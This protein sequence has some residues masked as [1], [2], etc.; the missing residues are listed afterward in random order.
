MIISD[1]PNATCN[2]SM[3]ADIMF[4]GNMLEMFQLTSEV[5]VRG[6]IIR[7]LNKPRDLDQL[8]TWLLKTCVDQLLLLI[9]AIVNRS[10]DESVMPLC[11]KG[12]NITPL[13]KRAG[14]DKEEMKNCRPISNLP[15]ISKRT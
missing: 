6:I 14:L 13:L 11:L 2:I 15:S 9:T 1:T 7:S 12:A 10:V 8:P 5:E 3:D 4:K